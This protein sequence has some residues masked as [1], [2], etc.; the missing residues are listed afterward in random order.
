MRHYQIFLIEDEVAETFFGDESKLFHLFVEAETTASPVYYKM[1]KKQIDY[2]TKPMNSI[3]MESHI[4]NVLRYRNGYYMYPGYHLLKSA[5][6]NS[7]AELT[8]AEDRMYIKS[9]GSIECE[10]T[11]FEVLR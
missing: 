2:I 1:I 9:S 8:F 7:R 11:F 10:T 3:A 6:G 4:E 5:G